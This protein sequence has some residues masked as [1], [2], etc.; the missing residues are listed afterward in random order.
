MSYRPAVSAAKG[1]GPR[2]QVGMEGTEELISQGSNLP[3]PKVGF[4]RGFCTPEPGGSPA[5]SDPCPS[6]T[7]QAQEVTAQAREESWVLAILREKI[8]AVVC[9]LSI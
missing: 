5:S 8:E 7:A 3:L 2:C 4:S 6:P 1:Q 9:F